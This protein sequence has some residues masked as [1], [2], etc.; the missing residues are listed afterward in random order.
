MN[1]R[2]YLLIVCTGKHARAYVHRNG[3]NFYGKLPY[4]ELWNETYTFDWKKENLNR[5]LLEIITTAYDIPEHHY[6]D[7]PMKTLDFLRYLEDHHI[8][9][10]TFLRSLHTRLGLS[11][12]MA[13]LN[14]TKRSNL[15]LCE[16]RNT[17]TCL[18]DA[19]RAIH[20]A[21]DFH[22]EQTQP[23]SQSG[24]PLLSGHRSYLFECNR[25]PDMTIH[26][27]EDG[28]LKREVSAD[29]ISFLGFNG[30]LD[31]NEEALSKHNLVKIYDS[32]VFDVEK[33]FEFLESLQSQP[34][35][36]PEL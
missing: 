1:L 8:D 9:H 4:R 2:R 14:S 27:P 34:V 33:A 5:R 22:V 23:H 29:F 30:P 17:P 36:N 6:D 10:G 11:L 7:K 25:G 13:S 28:S 35:F 24:R 32:E 26:D 20:I 12:H 18:V 3:K 31:D 16:P 19:I 15:G 21:C